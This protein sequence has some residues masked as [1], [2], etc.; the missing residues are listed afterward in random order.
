MLLKEH[1]FRFSPEAEATLFR[2]EELVV[3]IV[4]SPDRFR[5]KLPASSWA[6]ARTLYGASC[7]EAA[8]K[9]ANFLFLESCRSEPDLVTRAMRESPSLESRNPRN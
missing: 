2:V 5:L 6:D 7:H 8:E 9:A 3:S 4:G 1:Q